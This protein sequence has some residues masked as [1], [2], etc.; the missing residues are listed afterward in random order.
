MIG[1][2]NINARNSPLDSSKSYCTGDIA[3][4]NHLFHHLC[5]EAPQSNAHFP[6]TIKNKSH[7]M[8]NMIQ[9]GGRFLFPR[10][11]CSKMFRNPEFCF[12]SLIWFDFTITRA[13][14]QQWPCI[15]FLI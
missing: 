3:L 2:N 7:R 12:A 10:Q 13:S 4:Q 5:S 15:F 1:Y 11:K 8:R 9:Q 6:A 14:Q